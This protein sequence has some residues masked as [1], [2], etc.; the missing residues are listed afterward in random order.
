MK[1]QN[2]RSLIV[3]KM[4]MAALCCACSTNDV[5]PDTDDEI[6]VEPGI[7]AD[8]FETYD[9]EVGMVINVRDVARKGYKPTEAVIHV[10]ARTGD[11]SQTI[12]LDALAFMGEVK[13]PVKDLDDAARKELSEGVPVSVTLKDKDG[14]EI[15]S[16]ISLSSV[17]FLANPLPQ[18]INATLLAETEDAGTIRLNEGTD[19]YLQQVKED[20]TP[21]NSSMKWNSAIAYGEVMTVGANDTFAGEQPAHVLNFIPVPGQRNTFYILLAETGEYIFNTTINNVVGFPKI[22]LGPKNSHK[23]DINL[24]LINQRPL[25]EFHF[26]KVKD[27]VYTIRNSD[28]QTIEQVAGVGLAY[29]YTNGL[30]VFWRIVAKDIAWTAQ[31]IGTNIISPVLPNARTGFSFNSTLKNCGS[32]TLEQTVGADFSEERTN[33]IGW[34]ES[35]SINNTNT[36]S[37]STTVGVEFDATFFGTGARYNASVTGSLEWSQSVTSETS[38][39]ESQTSTKSETYFSSRTISVPSGKASLV[40]DAYQY[41][42][43]VRVEYVQ[44]LRLSGIDED[45]TPLTGEQIASLFQFTRFNGV[46]NTVEANSVVFTLRGHSILDKYIETQS[47]V[48]DVPANCN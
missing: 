15:M 43:N 6:I 47:N 1:A 41:Y 5:M 16:N 42:E 23:T 24:F 26:D 39:Y 14:K 13:I 9:G 11:Y 18:N 44:R 35:I 7:T 40:Y 34:E 10:D 22:F 3:I 4:I 12:P 45:G 37:I 48:D 38:E 28:D 31:S 19:Y 17:S 8:E 30:P 36:Q 32:G 33:T 21:L 27:G 2:K 29:D 20:G 46:I 25:A